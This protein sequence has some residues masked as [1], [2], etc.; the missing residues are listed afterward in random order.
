MLTV[1]ALIL[2]FCSSSIKLGWHHCLWQENKKDY[3]LLT[4]PA[5][6]LCLPHS[7]SIKSSSPFLD[8]ISNSISFLSFHL[9][10]H[11]MLLISQDIASSYFTLLTG[12]SKRSMGSPGLNCGIWH[13]W[14]FRSQMQWPQGKPTQFKWTLLRIYLLRTGKS[15]ISMG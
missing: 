7:S 8:S 14:A 4:A 12:N 1:L 3:L 6:L 15:L 5:Q 2:C 9:I 11:L 10:S 13:H